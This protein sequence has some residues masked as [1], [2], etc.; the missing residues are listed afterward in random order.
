MN[1]A[2]ESADVVIGS[3]LPASILSTVTPVSGLLDTLK[4]SAASGS[5]AKSG[6][7]RCSVVSMLA[8]NRT[9]VAEESEPVAM[10]IW[11]PVESMK[12]VPFGAL[13]SFQRTAAS[14]MVFGENV[15]PAYP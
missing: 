10:M 14:G 13:T 12:R 6:P 2:W 9:G 11:A 5:G 1:S 15:E 8:C 4:Y 3:G 7:T